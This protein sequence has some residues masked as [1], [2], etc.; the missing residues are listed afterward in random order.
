MHYELADYLKETKES[1]ELDMWGFNLWLDG[2]SIDSILEFDSFIN[3]YNNK[4][5]GYPRGGM[6]IQDD[7]L[8]WKQK[9]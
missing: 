1:D 7:I 4:N 5:H 9:R 8:K 2:D 3:I 6:N